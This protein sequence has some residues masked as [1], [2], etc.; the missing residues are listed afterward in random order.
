[1]TKLRPF[2]LREWSFFM[3]QIIIIFYGKQ[4]DIGNQNILLNVLKLKLSSDKIWKKF[5]ISLPTLE[6]NHIEV[7]GEFLNF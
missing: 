5:I 7:N 1:M 4:Y 2:L 3:Y 6:T